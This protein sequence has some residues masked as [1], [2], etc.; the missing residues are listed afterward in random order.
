MI[1][2]V[3]KEVKITACDICGLEL[4]NQYFETRGTSLGA[5]TSFVPKNSWTSIVANDNWLYDMHRS[6][7]LKTLE[8][9]IKKAKG[10]K[11]K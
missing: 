10:V 4:E 8:E 7:I 11:T 9:T 5:R 3:I 1:T 2:I 6:C